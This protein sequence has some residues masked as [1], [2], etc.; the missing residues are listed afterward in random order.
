M[1]DEIAQELVPE[2]VLQA[3]LDKKKMVEA[4]VNRMSSS[5]QGVLAVL[6]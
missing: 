3:S 6:A 5:V 2:L 4:F 1:K